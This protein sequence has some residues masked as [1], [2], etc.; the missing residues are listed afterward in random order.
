MLSYFLTI[1][2]NKKILSKLFHDYRVMLFYNIFK[3]LWN[4]KIALRLCYFTTFAKLFHNS[5]DCVS[6]WATRAFTPG[7]EP[8]FQMSAINCS[9]VGPA[10]LATASML[11][12][13]DLKFFWAVPL[14]DLCSLLLH[15][16][17]LLLCFL[18]LSSES[19]PSV[20]ES[21]DS[22]PFEVHLFFLLLHLHLE[23]S[24]QSSLRCPRFPHS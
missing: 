17:Y 19:L 20:E 11:T 4:N 13:F 18:H 8:R 21:D 14:P 15:C 3:K 22:P 5:F 24:G 23:I 9:T 7:L 2:K 16:P 6:F 1:G 10:G 12:F